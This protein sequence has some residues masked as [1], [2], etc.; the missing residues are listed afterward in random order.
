MALTDND[1]MKDKQRV[2]RKKPGDSNKA[3]SDEQ[4]ME[5][6]KLYLITGNLKQAAASLQIPEVT[7][8]YWKAKD[9][10]KQLEAEMRVSEQ[11]QLS[12]RMKR[13]VEKSMAVVEDRLEN[14]DWQYNS[15]TGQLFR[16]PVAMKDAHKV[17]MDMATKAIE[18]D[19]KR[20]DAPELEEATQNKFVEL[21]E[22]FA[23]L[24]Q[25]VIEKPPLEVTD[26]VFVENK[27][28]AD[29]VHEEREARLQDGI[30]EV[31]QPGRADQEP[32]ETDDCP[33]QG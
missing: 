1:R 10:W 33:P 8:R 7:A 2:A 23:A 6:C 15:K 26:V 5:L 13:L 17:T 22:K 9:W 20:V 11:I 4:K 24:A 21:A 25:K 16:K 3:W 32:L 14:G 29:A 28:Y 30:P 31:P 18:I 19:E 12:A 27:E